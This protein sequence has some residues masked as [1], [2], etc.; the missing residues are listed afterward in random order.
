MMRKPMNTT[1][2]IGNSAALTDDRTA[3]RASKTT[4]DII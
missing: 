3:T 1:A 2:M 4:A